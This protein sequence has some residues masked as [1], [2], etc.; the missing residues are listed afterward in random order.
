MITIFK[1]DSIVGFFWKK[2]FESKFFRYLTYTTRFI[3]TEKY[4]NKLVMN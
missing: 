1:E 3:P 2:T 4:P